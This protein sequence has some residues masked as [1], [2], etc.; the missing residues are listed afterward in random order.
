MEI[1]IH[2]DSSVDFTDVYA[3]FPG[4]AKVHYG[5]VSAGSVSRYES[6]LRAYSYS[7][8]KITTSNKTYV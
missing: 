1:R 8:L 7:Y 5:P 6:V 4:G 3:V 2:N